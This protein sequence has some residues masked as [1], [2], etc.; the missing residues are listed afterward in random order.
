M[1]DLPTDIQ[2]ERRRWGN[3]YLYSIKR[4]Q[5]S[6]LKRLLEIYERFIKPLEGKKSEEEIVQYV[7][8]YAEWASKNPWVEVPMEQ[9][10]MELDRYLKNK[11]IDT[12]DTSPRPGQ[13]LET[14]HILENTWSFQQYVD[15]IMSIDGEVS[16]ED[17]KALFDELKYANGRNMNRLMDTYLVWSEGSQ[18]FV[19]EP[20]LAEKLLLTD[21]THLKWDEFKT[22]FKGFVLQL[23]PTLFKARDRDFGDISLDTVLVNEIT[24]DG[25][26]ALSLLFMSQ[27]YP[28]TDELEV[29]KYKAPQD[30]ILPVFLCRAHNGKHLETLDQSIGYLN[31]YINGRL[32]DPEAFIVKE[33][34]GESSLDLAIRTVL[35][36]VTYINTMPNDVVRRPMSEKQKALIEKSKR[37][38]GAKRRKVIQ[39]LQEYGKQPFVVGTRVRIG[40][41]L[42]RVA[43]ALGSG[44]SPSVASYVRGH[45]ARQPHGP[46]NSLR[47]IIWREPHWSNIKALGVSQKTYRVS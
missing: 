25:N 32:D 15:T 5:I 2:Q 34:G 35:N 42:S 6:P 20:D 39:Q 46:R 21:T 1:K 14:M 16:P 30:V 47:K 27:S 44:R 7:D 36:I 17:V 29:I 38:Q 37:I 24:V 12:R 28:Y 11:E 3:A 4:C 13:L 9:F 41:E 23:P 19:I 26:R 8:Q 18:V 33:G 40:S 10:L 22:P 45:W 31:D 43:K